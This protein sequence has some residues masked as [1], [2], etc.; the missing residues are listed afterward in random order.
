[1]LRAIPELPPGFWAALQGPAFPSES[2]V[3]LARLHRLLPIAANDPSLEPGL[4]QAA[5]KTWE[6]E[7]AAQ[8]AHSHAVDE[9]VA[10]VQLLLRSEDVLYVKGVVFRRHLYPDRTLRPMNDLDVV[11]RAGRSAA[12]AQRLRA[13]GYREAAHRY[14][15]ADGW[16][17]PVELISRFAEPARHRIDHE[18]IFRER[19]LDTE[20]VPRLAAHH[21]LVTYGLLSATLLHVHLRK[22]LDLWLLSRDAAVLAEAAETARRWRMRRAFHASMCLVAYAFPRAGGEWRMRISG[23]SLAPSERRLVE[24]NIVPARTYPPAHPIRSKL[25]RLALLDSHAARMRVLAARLWSG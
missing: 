19:I 17:L 24:R 12:I 8:D 16:A 3:T 9:H 4:R 22:L 14:F 7:V 2:F 1:M 11:V 15:H 21:A 25:R 5:R 6:P 20:G 13:I 10:R 23:A 18:E